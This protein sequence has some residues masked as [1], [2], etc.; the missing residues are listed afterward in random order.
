MSQ[1]GYGRN[2]KSQQAPWGHEDDGK[3]L[4]LNSFLRRGF[5][6]LSL[7]FEFGIAQ[8]RSSQR[9]Q[10]GDERLPFLGG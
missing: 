1:G 7:L 2:E 8:A 6:N 9:V 10:E 5:E 4:R 3:G